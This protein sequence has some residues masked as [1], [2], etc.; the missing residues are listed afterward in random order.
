MGIYG[1]ASMGPCPFRHG[2]VCAGSIRGWYTAASMGPCPFR[3]GYA[4][5]CA[6]SLGVFLL[7]WGHALSGMDT[8]STNTPGWPLKTCFNGAMPFQAW[9]PVDALLLASIRKLLQWGHALS[10]M[11]TGTSLLSQQRNAWLQWGHALSG[12]DTVQVAGRDV[13]A[14]IASMGP[15]PFRHGYFCNYK[16]TSPTVCVLQWGHALSGMD[17]A[18]VSSS[19]IDSAA[20]FNGAMPFQAWILWCFYGILNRQPG[21][22]WGHALSGMDTLLLATTSQRP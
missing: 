3:H 22:Q 10:G 8:L 11:D 12:M 9:I 18:R 6:M 17:T 15:C 16:Y 19:S 2:Y 1:I 4:M 7:Q 20:C 13:R 21:L 14:N 5:C